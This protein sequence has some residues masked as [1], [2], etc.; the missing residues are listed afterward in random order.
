MRN[1]KNGLHSGTTGIS[2]WRSWSYMLIAEFTSNKTA[3]LACFT[4][5]SVFCKWRRS[6]VCKKKALQQKRKIATCESVALLTLNNSWPNSYLKI[7]LETCTCSTSIRWW[8]W[9][10][11]KWQLKK[12]QLQPLLWPVTFD[13]EQ[14]TVQ[15]Y[16]LVILVEGKEAGREKN[17]S[18]TKT[19]G[20]REEQEWLREYLASL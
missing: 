9:W 11:W 12:C 20:S 15:L 2:G 4:F 5:H 17:I 3:H 10:W 1:S 13:D 14:G 18:S 6:W 7:L 19:S 8:W 16:P